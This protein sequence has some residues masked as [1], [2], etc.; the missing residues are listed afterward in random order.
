MIIANVNIVFLITCYLF[1][2]IVGKTKKYITATAGS[3]NTKAGYN[4]SLVVISDSIL[5]IIGNVRKNKPTTAQ[6]GHSVNILV[7]IISILLLL[8]VLL[9]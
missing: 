7:S 2:L 4:V 8:L 3:K 1:F 5:S 9:F 6:K